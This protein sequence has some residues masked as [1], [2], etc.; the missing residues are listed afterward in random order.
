MGKNKQVLP[1]VSIVTPTFR[2]TE[3]LPILADC[4]IKQKYSMKKIEWVI[5]NGETDE[6]KFEDV[7][8][9][10]QEMKNTIKNLP[11]IV[12]NHCPMNKNNRIGGLRNKTNELAKGPI[13]VCMDDDDYYPPQRIIDAVKKLKYGKKHLAGCSSISVYDFDLDGYIDVGPFGPNHGTNNTFA[14]TKKYAIGNK[15]NTTLTHAEEKS[16]TNSF[17]NK[18]VQLD[19]RHCVVQFAHYKNTFN[20]RRIYDQT[21]WSNGRGEKMPNNV[22]RVSSKNI[23][24]VVG[25]N[26]FKDY[27]KMCLPNGRHQKKSDYDIVYYCGSLSIEWDPTKKSLGGS[28]QAVVEL[29]S[30]WAEKGYKVGVYANMQNQIKYRNVNYMPYND[31]K[32]S[33]KYNILVLWRSFGFISTIQW[34]LCADYICLDLHDTGS[35]PNLYKH[36]DKVNHV[37]VKSKYHGEKVLETNPKEYRD[38]IEP[39][40]LNIMNGVRVE[41]FK[42]DF[43]VKRNPY[44]LCYASCYTRGLEHF[45]QFFFPQLK[46]LI[47]QVELHI[48]YGYPK[49]DNWKSLREKLQKMI[50]ELDG[51]YEHGRVDMDVIIEEKQKSNFHLYYTSCPAETDCISV[52]ESLVAGCIPILSDEG[53]FKERDGIK[54]NQ[55]TN[56]VMSYYTLAQAV[57]NLMKQHKSCDMIREK[58]KKSPTILSW[59]DIG[60]EW[61]K[62]FTYVPEMVEEKITILD[63]NDIIIP[64]TI[65]QTW[66]TKK[67]S[68]YITSLVNKWK[69]NNHEYN[70]VIHDAKERA[71][72]IKD[73]FD[74]NVYEAYKK[75][76]PGAYQADFW[77]YCVLYINGGIYADIDTICMGK[78]DNF[79]ND[80][81]SFMTIVDFNRDNKVEGK[82]NLACGFIGAVKGHP[83]LM[84][85]INRI[86]YNIESNIIPP[87]K[88]DFSGPGILGR[89]FNDFLDVEETTSVVG[90]EG[91][92]LVKGQYIH[93]LKFHEGSELVTDIEDN[94]IFRNKNGDENLRKM[95][96]L[97][98]QRNNVKSWLVGNPI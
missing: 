48:Y 16:F 82:H 18:M 66:E 71:Q 86:V 31:F 7:P 63:D 87:S 24:T 67:L 91:R 51:V 11:N 42:K 76:I 65:Y 55:P 46:K 41:N 14:Y 4:I 79:I 98:C 74:D 28:E 58:L 40:I 94:I 61:M 39:K 90:K 70:Y 57:A 88:L 3:F 35:P 43:K 54:H 78:L 81:I 5:V 27:E 17:R 62:Y 89:S 44:R 77:R 59:A 49:G 23:K 38:K 68:P 72:F 64:K 93:L 37:Y 53:V 20:K 9:V 10:I 83:I 6:S 21:Y 26:K 69:E 1:C 80:K 96:S 95:Y 84:N 29:S 32:V 12:Y 30:H 73:N 97:E 19:K 50:S 8:K 13:I 36:I 45:L 85:C 25:E 15:Y 22:Y 60:D 75:I 34:N 56:K 52:R 33:D 47:P 2:R 92:H